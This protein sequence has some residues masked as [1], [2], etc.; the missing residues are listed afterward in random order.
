MWCNANNETGF[1]AINDIKKKNKEN[2]LKI[3]ATPY[4]E[5]FI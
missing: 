1:F 4:G 5:T 3:N 2:K